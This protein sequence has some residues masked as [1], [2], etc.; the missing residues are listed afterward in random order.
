M[1]LVASFLMLTAS[2]TAQ[3]DDCLF[4]PPSN[5]PEPPAGSNLWCHPQSK[6]YRIRLA[7]HIVRSIDG[8]G[9]V[10][11][12][13]EFSKTLTILSNDF[14]PIMFEV[15]KIDTVQS[16]TDK[17]YFVDNAYKLSTGA[18][19]FLSLVQENF[20][21]DALNIYIGPPSNV[22]DGGVASKSRLACTIGGSRVD[23]AGTPAKYLAT[24]H[25]ISHEVGHLLNL[26]HTFDSYFGVGY[27][28]GQNCSTTG[29]QVCDTPADNGFDFRSALTPSCTWNNTNQ[30]DPNG[31]LYQPSTTNP[32]AYTHLRCMSNF[33]QGQL[34][35][36]YE[37]VLTDPIVKPA[38]TIRDLNWFSGCGGGV[39]SA[40]SLV[41]IL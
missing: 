23:L 41:F 40:A 20:I 7:F 33:T 1:L 10:I 37:Y 24:T 15:I 25:A 27:V 9:A 32:M 30:L 12:P 11:T 8:M 16:T 22:N 34:R 19:L 26:L 38:V 35:R 21:S 14:N 39:V 6:E 17:N 5:N 31:Q 2:L 36:M 13:A 4:D 28:N 29:D 18:P 3:T